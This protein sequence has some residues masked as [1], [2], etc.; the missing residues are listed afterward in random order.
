MW[1]QEVLLALWVYGSQSSTPQRTSRDNLFLPLACGATHKAPSISTGV[2]FP[3]LGPCLESRYTSLNPP[4]LSAV[5]SASVLEV[6]PWLSLSGS[7]GRHASLWGTSTGYAVSHL[8][9]ASPCLL[10]STHLPLAKSSACCSALAPASLCLNY[11][12]LLR[13][14]KAQLF[15]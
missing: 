13:L 9:W 1:V 5:T 8:D 10:L 15:S 14:P 6:Q 12:P 3:V 4:L 2:T 11:V 7:S